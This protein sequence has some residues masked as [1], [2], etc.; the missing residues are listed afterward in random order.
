MKIRCW[1]VHMNSTIAILCFVFGL[2]VVPASFIALCIWMAKRR[3]HWLCYP[4]YFFLFGIVGG[5][6]IAL[7]FS[8]SGL[9]ALCI[10]FLMTAAPI[11]CFCSSV[12]LHFRRQRGRF[13]NVA[14]ILGYGYSGLI[15]IAFH[16]GQL[17]YG[18]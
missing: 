4:A 5:A 16:G 17:F 12:A 2:L 13:E 9:A 8:P 18:R 6:C 10:V 3:V 14:M 15:F 1:T 11:A 7:G